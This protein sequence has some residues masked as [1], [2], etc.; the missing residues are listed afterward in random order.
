MESTNCVTETS[1]E[2][3]VASVGKKGTGKLV[4]KAKPRTDIK[5][6]VVSSVFF[7]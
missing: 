7:S 4:A 6:D 3:H 1:E 5:F 2:I